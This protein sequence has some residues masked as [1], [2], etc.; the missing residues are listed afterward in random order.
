MPSAAAHLFHRA[1]AVSTAA[2]VGLYSIGIL[3]A[4]TDPARAQTPITVNVSVD[5]AAVGVPL[6][7]VWPFYG[8]D[9]INYTTT[10]E[11]RAL[12]GTLAAAHTAPVHIRSHYLFNDGDGT[13]ALKWGS[14]NVYSEDT[15]GNPNYSWALT[16]EIFDALRSAGVSPFVELGFMPEALSSHPTPY[17]NSTGSLLDSGCFYPPTDYTKW[18]ALIRTWASHANERYPNV[19]SSWLWELWNEPDIPYWQGT[20]EEYATL[21]DHTEAALHGVLPRAQLGGPA[22]AFVANAFLKKFLEHC[23]TGS[24]A[25]SG[26][27]GTRLDLVS[28]HAKGGVSLS[29]GHV[30]MNLGGQLR[31]HRLGFKTV[32]AFPQY[33]QTPI[34][35]TEA[36]PDGCAACPVSS[37][38]ANAYRNSA[39]YGAYELAVMKRSLE[40]E[41]QIGVKLGGVLTWAFTFP[42]TPY[43]AGYRSLTT[44][45]IG[46]PVLSAFKLL[47]K[48]E[49]TRLPLTS[50]G[51]RSLDEIVANGVSG[52]AEIDA[53]ATRNGDAIQVLVWNYHDELV[54]SPA[55]PVHLAIQVKEGFGPRVRVSHLRLDESHGDAYT[56]WVAQGSPSSP[57][58]AQVAA[59]QKAMEPSPLTPDR[60]LALSADGSFELNFDL[61]RFGVSLITLRATA[62]P[63]EPVDSA[64]SAATPRGGCAYH[65]DG[66][67]GDRT[68]QL[69]LGALIVAIVAGRRRLRCAAQRSS[70]IG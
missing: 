27:T 17:R 33:R 16:D 36:D 48:L 69:A 12:L 10:L 44:N 66:R 59:L 61:P 50:T 30:Q 47:G 53:M 28:F 46:L 63:V 43:F 18:A 22:V 29:E 57:S 49:G 24:N 38:P 70:V 31:L 6:E 7:R 51:A 34:Y 3:L 37:A 62:G 14:T 21:Y 15:A 11:G 67:A 1:L 65:A 56:A 52:Q 54:T 40:L 42:D 45:G 25:V 35:I 13:P 19:E 64:S 20:F 39:A 58:T 68:V 32:A 8:Y 4:L 55:T 23:A 9:E 5:A 2:R 26:A 60:T 41:A